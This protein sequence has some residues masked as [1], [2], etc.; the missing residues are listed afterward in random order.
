[1]NTGI[2]SDVQIVY[3]LFEFETI[4]D[5][6]LSIVMYIINNMSK[7]NYID[8]DLLKNTTTI[9]GLKNTLL[10]RENTN[11]LSV[12]IKKD[13]EDSINDIYNEIMEY[14]KKEIIDNALPTDIMTFC[15]LG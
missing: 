8:I 9:N 3:N 4:V 6:D 11:P 15:N 5:V 7:S 12:I 10:F 1:M 2:S 14:H 13:Y